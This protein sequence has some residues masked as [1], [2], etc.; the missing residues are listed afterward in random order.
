MYIPRQVK[1]V[2]CRFTNYSKP[3]RSTVE[4]F[5]THTLLCSDTII[6]EMITGVVKNSKFNNWNSLSQSTPTNVVTGSYVTAHLGQMTTQVDMQIC[7]IMYSGGL[8]S[9]PLSGQLF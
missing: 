2:T 4:N 7:C 3:E 5:G 1:I 6:G 9:I 8:A